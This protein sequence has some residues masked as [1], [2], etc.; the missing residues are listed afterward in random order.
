MPSTNVIGFTLV[1]FLKQEVIKYHQIF[2]LRGDFF[3]VWNIVCWF[4]KIT[5]NWLFGT[6]LLIFCHLM[7][8]LVWWNLFSQYFISVFKDI[9]DHLLWK[10]FFKAFSQNFILWLKQ[11]LTKN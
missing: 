8:Q 9:H 6:S 4:I 3:W 7:N 1:L 11:T 2:M 5:L 10:L